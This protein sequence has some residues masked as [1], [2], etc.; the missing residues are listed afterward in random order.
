[1]FFKNQIF[2]GGRALF[3]HYSLR[4]NFMPHPEYM[5]AH[6]LSKDLISQE[7]GPSFLKP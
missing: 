2:K 4:F 6:W 3:Q 1:M 7:V 5:R